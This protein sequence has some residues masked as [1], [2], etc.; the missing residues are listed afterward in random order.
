MESCMSGGIIERKSTQKKWHKK[1]KSFKKTISVL[2]S[3]QK[4]LMKMQRKQAPKKEYRKLTIQMEG[5][6][7]S[8]SSERDVRYLSSKYL[9]RL[10]LTTDNQNN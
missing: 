5:I 4:T 2:K 9:K 6:M 7:D 1:A 8:S 3:Q 10:R